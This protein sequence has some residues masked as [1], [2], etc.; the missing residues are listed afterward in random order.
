CVMNETSTGVRNPIE[1]IGNVVAEYPD[2][3]FVV[4]AISALGGDSVDIEASNIDVIFTSVQKAFAMPPGLAVC[5]VSDAV[6]EREVEKD[7]AGWYGGFQRNLDY[8][9]R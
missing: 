7:A 4:D 2:T 8:Y 6:Y 1:E 9:D 3:Y 5:V